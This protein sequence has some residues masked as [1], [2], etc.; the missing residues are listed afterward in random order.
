MSTSDATVLVV[1][2]DPAVRRSVS[3]L[4]RS[5][6]FEVK[7]FAS[8]TQFLR[9]QLP[10]GPTC[11]LLDMCM[12]E[13]TGLDVQEALRKNGRHVPVVFLSGRGTVPT[14]TAGM[15]QGAEDFLVRKR[16][17]CRRPG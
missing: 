8:P 1:D 4:A 3:R 17:E 12:G 10:Q 14:A 6:G 11:V 7:A 16:W 2:D 9:Q 5:A 15:K 13:L